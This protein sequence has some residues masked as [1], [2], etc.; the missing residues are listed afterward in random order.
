MTWVF[1]RRFSTMTQATSAMTMTAMP[2]Q[3]ST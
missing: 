1:S 2:I 3:V